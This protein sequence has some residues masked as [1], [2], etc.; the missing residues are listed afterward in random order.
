[1]GYGN[2]N[3]NILFSIPVHEKPEVVIDQLINI[4]RFNPGSCIVLHISKDFDFD[5]A[6]L[7]EKS[8]FELIDGLEDVIVN[9]NRLRSGFEDIIQCHIS[10]FRYACKKTVFEHIAFASS[11]ELFILPGLWEDIRKYD[12]G[13]CDKVLMSPE[14]SDIQRIHLS[15]DVDFLNDLNRQGISHIYKGQFEGSFMRRE[16]MERISDEIE[17]FYDYQKMNIKYA[18]EEIFFHTFIDAFYPNAKIRKGNTTYMDW[19]NGLNVSVGDVMNLVRTPVGKYSVKRI[20]RRL[21]DEVRTFIREYV[22]N[23]MDEEKRYFKNAGL[24]EESMAIE[25]YRKANMKYSVLLNWFQNV[26]HGR[27]LSGYLTAKNYSCISIY[28]F[29]DIGKLLYSEISK[30]AL[31]NVE[32][33]IDK[34]N[35]DGEGS[36]EIKTPFPELKDSDIIIVTAMGDKGL[37]RQLENRYSIPVVEITDLWGLR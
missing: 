6:Y 13:P 23:Y 5:S 25:N 37:I 18:R 28:G 36:V 10:N 17:S 11:N 16:M 35:T 31:I 33:I 22:G 15:R 3:Y 14:S 30:E 9:P 7:S 27:S 4:H 26:M 32:A 34:A 29:G 21:N 24:T 19:A 12:C 20:D 2:K 8:F 1:M